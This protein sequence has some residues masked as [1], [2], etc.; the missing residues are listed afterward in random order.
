MFVLIAYDIRS[1]RTRRRV[2]E[3]LEGYGQRVQRSVFECDLTKA[4]YEELRT[5]LDALRG[6]AAASSIRCYHLCATC[7]GKVSLL[8]GGTLTHAASCQVV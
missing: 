1:D 5:K 4:Q 8:G 6:D 7:V 3:T 2:A